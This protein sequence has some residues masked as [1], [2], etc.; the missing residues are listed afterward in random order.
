MEEKENVTKIT[1]KNAVYVADAVFPE[2]ARE[3]ACDKIQR[4]IMDS[5]KFHSPDF[6]DTPE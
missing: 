5:L 4:L 2:D 6:R 3:T 1:V